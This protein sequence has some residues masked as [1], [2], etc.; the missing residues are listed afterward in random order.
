[1]ASQ[2]KINAY[3]ERHRISALFEDL[4]NKVLR[5]LPEE[6]MIYILR[7][8]YKQAG[9]E[10]PQGIRYGGLR[11]RTLEL[12]PSASPERQFR[13]TLVATSV[14]QEVTR[15]YERP[16]ATSPTRR[17]K[18]KHSE[19]PTMS[20]KRPDWNSD[21]TKS[22]LTFDELWENKQEKAQSSAAR[23]ST[24]QKSVWDTVSHGVKSLNAWASV[25]LDEKETYTSPSQS[26]VILSHPSYT[27]DKDLLLSETVPLS[28]RSALVTPT[29]TISGS[30]LKSNR[31]KH[32]EEYSQLLA[33]VDYKSEDS[34]S[35]VT[36]QEEE[37]IELLE[38]A[39]DLKNEGVR[40]IPTSGL[41][42]SQNLRYRD[43]EPRVKLNI[44]VQPMSNEYSFDQELVNE[45]DTEQSSTDLK[46]SEEDEEEFESVSQVTG[47]R[48][49]VW[50]IPDSDIES[51]RMKSSRFK[52]VS[53]K[54]SRDRLSGVTQKSVKNSLEGQVTFG[55]TNTAASPSSFYSDSSNGW[56]IPDDT[57]SLYDWNQDVRPAQDPRAY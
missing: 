11:K 14:D 16:W 20:K 55:V 46:D 26:G 23:K 34:G 45:L 3:M 52:D 53:K 18:P 9:I 10:I 22:C 40:N 17:T 5:D 29:Q 44:N 13:S 56:M 12:N 39:D 35:E 28:I 15:D 47:P 38:N 21:K 7:A 31:K 1:M 41:K 51:K 8:I 50:K 49:P 25:G 43:N 33:A 57:D 32:K 48:H 30:R 19:E 54:N 27:S 2:S 36:L 4:M 37:A 6:P 24:N 42:L